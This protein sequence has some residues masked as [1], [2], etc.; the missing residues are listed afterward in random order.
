[1]QGPEDVYLSYLPLAHVFDRW[2]GEG[3]G[4]T[5]PEKRSVSEK[6]GQEGRHLMGGSD[7]RE[8]GGHAY[9]G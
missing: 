7:G 9:E 8:I 1:M 3:V 2:G 6:G 4:N 5:R